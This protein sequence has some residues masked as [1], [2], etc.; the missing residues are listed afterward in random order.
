MGYTYYGYTYSGYTYH[1]S[2]LLTLAGILTYYGLHVLWLHLLYLHLPWLPTAHPRR[3]LRDLLL[4]P[5]RHVR[6]D[7]VRPHSPSPRPRP[8]PNPSPSPTPT[9][10]LPLTRCGQSRIATFE[11]LGLFLILCIGADDIFVWID[12][13]KERAPM[14]TM[15][16]LT[17]AILT[18]RAP[19]CLLYLLWL[20]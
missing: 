11:L 9:P 7:A 8:R 4:D 10:T 1:G 16:I 2:L 20:Y 17:M 12:T 18:R 13:W 5:S 19:S 3:P 6:M 14:I 15:A